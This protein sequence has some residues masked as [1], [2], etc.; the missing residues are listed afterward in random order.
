VTE[1]DVIKVM[2]DLTILLI[3]ITIPVYAISASFL[4]KEYVKTLTL[5]KKIR[6][7][8]EDSLASNSRPDI[9]ETEKKIEAFREKEKQLNRRI[10]CLSLFRVVI[11]PNV[12]FG[13]GLV[14]ACI[15]ILFYPTGLEYYFLLVETIL[16][17][18][19]LIL[20]G[21]A[22]KGI[23]VVARQLEIKEQ[24]NENE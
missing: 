3:S 24:G 8:A 18:I 13:L 10:K 9:D 1:L 20:F 12:F 15:V 14:I 17:A 22:L 2:V 21:S 16:L 5:I 11:L 7:E 23:E 4:G 19:G 6:N